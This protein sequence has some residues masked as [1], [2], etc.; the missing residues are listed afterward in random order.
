MGVCPVR[1]AI[2]TRNPGKVRPA[3]RAVDLICGL[4]GDLVVVDPPEG[5]SPQ[6]VGGLEVFRGA[7]M[8]AVTA[9]RAVGPSG[10]G[11]G[12]EAGLV[13]FYTGVGFLE[14]QVAVV[15]GPGGRY[16]VGA[17]ASFELP[18]SIEDRMKR[19]EELGSLVTARR[20][21]GDIGESIGYIGIATGGV[22]TREDLTFQAVAMALL[23]WRL[24]H[25]DS[26]GIV[27]EVAG[28]I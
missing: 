4:R 1:A 13:E 16:S 8:R 2:A 21:A 7:F 23:P 24:G 18:Q 22:I 14:T 27:D 26:L 28:N 6:P 17:S 20:H 12:V 19:G 11:I 25:I 15:V 10:L 5:L 3:R 9:H